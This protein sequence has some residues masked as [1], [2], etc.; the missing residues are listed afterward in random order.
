M[1]IQDSDRSSIIPL[2]CAFLPV[3]TI[4]L[5]CTRK[6]VQQKAKARQ[7]SSWPQQ[8][9]ACGFKCCKFRHD[10]HKNG[11]EAK[12]CCKIPYHSNLHLHHIHL[13]YQMTMHLSSQCI[14]LQLNI[15]NWS[16]LF[17]LK[18]LAAITCK[19]SE[20]WMEKQRER[21]AGRTIHVQLGSMPIMAC[22]CNTPL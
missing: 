20:L 10:A 15:C 1:K 19:F 12:G 22:K 7:A 17:S 13:G 16:W 6:M 8:S 3:L 14:S 9:M 4:Y 5:F 21:V 11:W 2:H 18:I